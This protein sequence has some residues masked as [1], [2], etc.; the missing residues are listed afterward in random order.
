[1]YVSEESDSDIV[2]MNPSNN[3]GRGSAE[4]GEGRPLIKEN[5]PLPNT[6]PTPGGARV[7]QGLAGVRQA[8]RFAASHPR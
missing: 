5:I 4:K 6:Y 7:S 2:P 8:Q 3:D 1:M